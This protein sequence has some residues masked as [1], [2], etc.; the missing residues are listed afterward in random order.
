M[1]FPFLTAVV[2]APLITE[3]VQ[4]IKN[5]HVKNDTIVWG[6]NNMRPQSC[7]YKRKSFGFFTT[8]NILLLGSV[9]TLGRDLEK[10]FAIIDLKERLLSIDL[11]G[12]Y[13]QSIISFIEIIG[14]QNFNLNQKIIIIHNNF[15]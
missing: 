4:Y 3:H 14:K 5:L 8:T 9:K 2:Y 10:L 11:I 15:N 7:G 12:K 13:R 1:N 6:A